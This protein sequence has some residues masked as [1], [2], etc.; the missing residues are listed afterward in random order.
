[1]QPIYMQ[2]PQKQKTFS[3]IVFGFLKFILNLESFQKEMI[4]ISDI[5]WKLRTLKNVVR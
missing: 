4:F 1:M 5:F 3:G 2:L